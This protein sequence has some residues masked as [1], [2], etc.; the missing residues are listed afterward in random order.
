MSKSGLESSPNHKDTPTRTSS[1]PSQIPTIP[2]PYGESEG[3]RN[4]PDQG[5]IPANSA[6]QSAGNSRAG[7]FSRQNNDGRDSATG[8]YGKGGATRGGPEVSAV[9]QWIEKDIMLSL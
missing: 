5:S 2:L 4:R 9:A 8:G 6:S 7:V 3:A 1:I